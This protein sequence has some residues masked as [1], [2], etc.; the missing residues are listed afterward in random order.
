MDHKLL[1]HKKYNKEIC[2]FGDY[3]L[4]LLKTEMNFQIS[5][6]VTKFLLGTLENSHNCNQQEV[7]LVIQATVE[8]V[9]R[10]ELVVS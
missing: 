7:P 9:K 5:P 3:R 6:S 10:A 8:G 1:F 4:S 2:Y